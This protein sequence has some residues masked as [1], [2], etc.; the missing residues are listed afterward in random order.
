MMMQTPKTKVGRNNLTVMSYR[1]L[2]QHLARRLRTRVQVWGRAGALPSSIEQQPR[3]LGALLTNKMRPMM[4]G[5]APM[6]SAVRDPAW[7]AQSPPTTA[8]ACS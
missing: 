2:V 1:Q 5:T 4:S 7:S 8:P 3:T 6:T